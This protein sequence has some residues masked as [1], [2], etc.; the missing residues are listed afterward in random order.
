MEGR[1]EGQAHLSFNLTG[2]AFEAA[3]TQVGAMPLPP[4][5]ADKGVAIG[6]G[7]FSHFQFEAWNRIDTVQIEAVCS[8]TASNAQAVQQKY[9]I[10]RHY[11]DYR[12]MIDHEA[13]DFVDIITPPETHLEMC[14]YAAD[15]GIAII[16]QKPL[17]PTLEEARELVAYIKE[18]NVPFMVH[19]NWRFQP[20]FRKIKALLDENQIGTIHSAYFKNRMGDGWGDDAYIPRQPYFR[21]YPRLIVYENGIHFIDTFR[22]LF[23]E[24][25]SVYAKLRKLNPVIAGEDCA[26]VNFEFENGIMAVWDANRYNEPNYEK[27]RYTFGEMSIDG[28]AGSI[29]LYSDGRITVQKLGQPEQTVNYNPSQDNFAGDCVYVTQNH[30]INGLE[31]RE[32]ETNG[33]EYLKSIVVQEGIYESAH[34]GSVVG[35]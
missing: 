35:F 14:K 10:P 15:H 3:L 1:A 6:T 31:Q 8:R 26:L 7:Y 18:R 21:E 2:D 27:P 34:N 11:T 33:D 19:E 20:W 16:C 17:A 23:G 25:S 9:G 13:P 24:V 12:Q 32:F 28:L 5:I 4:Y 22:Y 30:F 29:R